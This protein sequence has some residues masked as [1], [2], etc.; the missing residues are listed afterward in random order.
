MNPDSELL[1][2]VESFVIIVKIKTI[3]RTVGSIRIPIIL[4]PVIKTERKI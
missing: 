3:D 2:F 4:T 1:K